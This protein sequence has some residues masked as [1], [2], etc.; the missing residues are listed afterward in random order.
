M[1]RLFRK[2]ADTLVHVTYTS[3]AGSPPATLTGTQEH[4]FWSATRDA[5]AGMDELHAGGDVLAN[6]RAPGVGRALVCW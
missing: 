2:E 5:R 4:S 6:A 1:V 3:G